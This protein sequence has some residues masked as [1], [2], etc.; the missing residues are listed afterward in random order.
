M[1]SWAS[2]EYM[3]HSMTWQE[4]LMYY[5]NGI[6]FEETKS[7]ILRSTFGRAMGNS[8]ETET[9]TP[10]N[11]EDQ[12]PDRAALYALYGDSIKRG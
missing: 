9:A 4:I 5:E 10:K 7:K 2:P 11:F 12:T 3:L 6:K 1:Y 8:N